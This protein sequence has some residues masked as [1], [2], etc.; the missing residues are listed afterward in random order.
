M[1]PKHPSVAS[2]R[3]TMNR[4]PPTYYFITLSEVELRCIA[5]EQLTASVE[6]QA[7]AQVHDLEQQGIGVDQ[8]AEKRS[9]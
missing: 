5:A 7:R 9:A 1:K 8:Q 4:Q 3:E 2:M 6:A